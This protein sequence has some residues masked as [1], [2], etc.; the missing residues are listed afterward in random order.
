MLDRNIHKYEIDP[1][2][3]K[4]TLKEVRPIRTLMAAG[5][6]NVNIQAGRYYYDS[7]EEIPEAELKAMGLD[8][9]MKDG[10][11]THLAPNPIVVEEMKT[12]PK[13]VLA[14]LEEGLKKASS[15]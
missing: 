10:V 12:N 6:P 4:A 14:G 2:S 11:P 15:A 1:V 7:G 13:G 3:G 8:P 9:E 5:R